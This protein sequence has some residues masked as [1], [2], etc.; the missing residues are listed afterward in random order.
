MSARRATLRRTAVRRGSLM[1]AAA[2]AVL[3]GSAG[4]AV[5]QQALTPRFPAVEN[6]DQPGIASRWAYVN[7]PVTARSQPSPTAA[8]AGRLGIRTE[9]GTDELVSVLG[10]S[11][12]AGGRMWL[13]VSLPTRPNGSTGWV[14]RSALG[15]LVRVRTWLRIDLRRLRLELIRSGRVVMVARIGAGRSIW[16]TPRGRFYVRDRLFGPS[17]GAIYGPLAFGTSA[18]SSVLTDWPGGGV[19]GI[20]GTNQPGLLPGHVSHGCI[21]LR[22]ADIVR[23]GHLLV[24]G[25]PVTIR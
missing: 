23:L 11:A 1:A 3:L 7:A 18:H 21:R 17:L 14:P 20:H 24:L 22:N 8:R 5:A 19:I 13:H 12:D 15:T 9:D 25:T 16:P 10:R 4:Q 6:L 2:L